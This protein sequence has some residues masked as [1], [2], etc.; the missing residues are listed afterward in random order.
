[1]TLRQ[2]VNLVYAMHVKDMPGFHDDAATCSNGCRVCFDS[3]LNGPLGTVTG[4]S[5]KRAHLE[6]VAALGVAPIKIEG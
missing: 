5:S 6:Q 4:A 3:T 1:M 2:A